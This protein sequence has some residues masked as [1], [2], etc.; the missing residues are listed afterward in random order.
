MS[1]RD[2][3]V[4]FLGDSTGLTKATDESDKKAN[5]FKKSMEALGKTV[6]EAEGPTAK[7]K[8]GVGG[9]GDMFKSAAANPMAMAG[10]VGAVVG[11]AAKAVS[12]FEQTTLEV[13]KFRD[14]THTTAED[15][16]RLVEH[17]SDIGVSS[18]E[19][20]KGLGKMNLVLGKSPQK[21]AELGVAI[22]KNKDGTENVT[23]TFEN[24]IEKLHGTAS[25]AE[26]AKIGQELLGKGWKTFSEDVAGGSAKLKQSLADV[27]SSKVFNDSDLKSGRDLRNAFDSIKDA[28]E[29]LFLTLGKALAPVIAELAPKFGEII[30][31]AEPLVGL[32]GKGLV[33]AFDYLKP[34][35]WLITEALKLLGPVINFVSDAATKMADV[36]GSAVDA[37]NPFHN[38]ADDIKGSADKAGAAFQAMQAAAADAA[39]G[40]NAYGAELH[41]A[42]DANVVSAEATKLSTEATKGLTDALK[43]NLDEQ[44]KQIDTL[45]SAANA[46]YDVADK[47]DKYKASLSGLDNTITAAKGNQDLINAAY[48]SN[49]TDAAALSDA[50]VHQREEQDKANGV[51]TSAATKADLWNG[52][53]VNAAAFL[54]GPARDSLIEYTAQVN[55]IPPEVVTAIKAALDKGDIAGANAAL[56]DTSKTR[57]ASVQ[58][59]ADQASLDKASGKIDQVAKNRQILLSVLPNIPGLSSFPAHARGTSNAENAFIAGENGPE[60]IVGAGGSKVFTTAETGRMLSGPP[61]GSPTSRT[62]PLYQVIVQGNVYGDSHIVEI[63]QAHTN[64]L[65][66][67]IAAGRRT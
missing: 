27:Q 26:Q 17:F 4:R 63:V 30:H 16:S 8:A 1:G 61:N 62:G 60:L 51:T 36:I 59:D 43:A 15:A 53:M 48:R 38:A 44:Q 18:E 33:L 32:I 65:A 20:E 6:G 7:L 55:G 40:V 21:F 12:M 25:A 45:R 52:S 56:A 29:G 39:G 19:A 66:A 35:I 23:A 11:V 28:V 34:S 14:A 49:T 58:V 5:S 3:L 41:Q 2:I 13:G 10:A 47:T 24:V 67:K 31:E 22:A 9:L 57:T 54:K 50:I 64:E 37:I 42:H 46:N